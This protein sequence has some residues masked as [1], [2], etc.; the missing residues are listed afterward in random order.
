[1]L[2]EMHCIFG[3]KS[4]LLGRNR[5]F[6]YS[7]RADCL[8]ARDYFSAEP[9]YAWPNHAASNKSHIEE[10]MMTDANVSLTQILVEG[11]AQT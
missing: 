11:L 3:P 5:I 10:R 9:V 6:E 1:M 7:R 4:S 8:R 2:F